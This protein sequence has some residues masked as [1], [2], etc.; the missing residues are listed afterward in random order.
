[1]TFEDWALDLPQGPGVRRTESEFGRLG[2]LFENRG[3]VLARRG[4]VETVGERIEDAS[5]RARDPLVRRIDGRSGGL[6]PRPEQI[7]RGR[8]G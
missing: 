8:G 6:G 3:G 4:L 7:R 5:D 1:M 2:A